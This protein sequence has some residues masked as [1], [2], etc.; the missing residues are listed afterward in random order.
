V[1]FPDMA[2]LSLVSTLGTGQMLEVGLIGP[3]GISTIAVF[4]GV[5]TM[6][7]DTVVL[8]PGIARRMPVDVFRRE[9][10]RDEAVHTA[11]GRFAQFLLIQS[12]QMSI[13]NSFH[14]LDQRCARWLLTT[15]DLIGEGAIPVTHE[16]LAT[17]LGVRRSSVTLAIGALAQDRLVHEQRGLIVIRDRGRLEQAACECY[18]S[19]RD[20]R[21]K[22]LGFDPS[23]SSEELTADCPIVTTAGGA[24][25]IPSPVAIP[26]R[27][28]GATL[29]VLFDHSP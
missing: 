19:V 9:V 17:M 23:V 3:D 24:D 16:L 7:C 29:R 12:M 22:L 15:G 13:C 27:Q 2:V 4:P 6:P 11:A 26:Q 8:I 21:R 14:S 28:S 18:R 5:T 10:V 20:E 25:A 1:Y